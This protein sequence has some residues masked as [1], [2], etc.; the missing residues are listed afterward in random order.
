M[1]VPAGA[2]QPSS[3][4]HTGQSLRK[5]WF[6]G[7]GIGVLLQGMGLVLAFASSVLVARLLGPHGL[8]QY[9]YVLAIVAVLSV[10]ATFG[11]PTIVTRMLAAY[12]TQGEWGAAQ[13]LLRWS[14][15]LVGAL[16]G[17]LGSALVVS[18]IVWGSDSHWSLY[19]L[20]APLIV[21]LAWANLRQRA[22]QGLH[23]PLASQLPEQFVKHTVFLAI[24]G[25]LWIAGVPFIML[26][27]GVMAAWLLAGIVSL[28]VGMVLL[29]KFSP[30]VLRSAEP[31]YETGEWLKIAL[32][33]YF[34]DVLA[35]VL[36]NSDT[37]IMGWLRPLDEVG[38]YQVALRLSVLML[39]LLG[40]SN[41]VLA[42]WFARFHATSEKVR[43]Q[44]VVTKTTRAIFAATIVIYL[45]LVV[46]GKPL[47]E[48]FFGSNF[49]AAY[50]ILIILGA[51]Q[52]VN[53]ASGPVVNLLAMMGGQRELAMSTFGAVILNIVL[54]L[55]LIP[56]FGPTGAAA[57][58]AVST[59]AYNVL[60]AIV[61]R[62]RSGV[63]A[64]I[65]G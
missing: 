11:L 64:T 4:V 47:L 10:L 44:S 30:P 56:P 25:G 62:R 42:P 3:A 12:Q 16:G 39:V 6:Q 20:A 37:I 1:T 35:V 2:Q 27:E 40:A 38:L 22:L 9:S 23:R 50:P 5:H 26:A 19:L 18:G 36:A 31:I 13:G 57:S 63:G 58:V 15:L 61:V 45:I 21:I 8:G 65:L 55:L 48:I 53:V 52:L 60:L 24:G 17:V 49:V 41:W 14:N 34:A 28:L 32:P 51:G 54:C 43:L 33:I 46:W 7:A 59:S 29:L